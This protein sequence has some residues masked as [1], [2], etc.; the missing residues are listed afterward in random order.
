MGD[1]P[2]RRSLLWETLPIDNNN[3]Y[4][5][6]RS[7][8]SSKKDLHFTKSVVLKESLETDDYAETG[9]FVEVDIS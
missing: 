3:M 4:G 1:S 7:Q 9:Y 6:S 5:W 2:V 8:L